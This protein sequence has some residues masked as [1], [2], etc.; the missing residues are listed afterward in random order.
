MTVADPADNLPAMLVDDAAE[1][2]EDTAVVIDVL[3]NDSDPE[4]DALTVTRH[5]GASEWL[6][7]DQCGRDR[8]LHARCRLYGRGHV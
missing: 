8:D 2:D 7:C 5:N 3:G 1:T 6:G 4:G